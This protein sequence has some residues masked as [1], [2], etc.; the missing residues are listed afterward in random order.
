MPNAA[1]AQTPRGGT[2]G[3]L[4]IDKIEHL[5]YYDIGGIGFRISSSDQS[6]GCRRL[7][8]AAMRYNMWCA[9]YRAVQYIVFGLRGEP[10]SGIM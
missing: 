8:D 2:G 4:W 6:S 3:F 7:P 5:C 9:L 1:A 10:K